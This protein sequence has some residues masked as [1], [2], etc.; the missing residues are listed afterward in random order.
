MERLL[1]DGKAD[2]EKK[3]IPETGI[4][5]VTCAMFG[6]T[7][8]EVDILP[9]VDRLGA[10]IG[11]V[12]VGVHI[13]EI[14]TAGT[15]KTGHRAEFEGE[16]GD[17]INKVFVNHLMVLLIPSPHL[18][19][20]QGRLARGGRFEIL[21]FGQ[22]EGQALEGQHIR[23]IILIVNRERLTPVALAAEDGIAKSEI[24]RAAADAHFL[25][26]VDYRFH[27][28]FDLHA[29]HRAAIDGV[30]LLTVDALLPSAGVGEMRGVE[31]GG[32]HLTDRQIEMTGKSKVAAVMGRNGHDGTGAV[33][34]Q[35]IFGNPNGYL[36]T[37]KGIDGKSTCENARN[38]FHLGLTLT[39][40]AVLGPS[41]ISLHLGTLLGSGNLVNHFMFRAEHHEGDAID[42]IGTGGKNLE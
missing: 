1:L 7:D 28:I 18:S 11:L 8:I 14:V 27:G 39:L 40:R 23:T 3:F 6:A 31:V 29:T 24:D 16:D 33:T 13:T 19:V 17:I 22:L 35:H 42:G 12:V 34:G 37:C 2:V 4:D 15:G 10:K 38:L 32:N 5:E 9:V 20:T 21:D 25:Y 30:A 26:F 41:D 36:L